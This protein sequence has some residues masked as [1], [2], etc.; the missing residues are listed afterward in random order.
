MKKRIRG[1]TSASRGEKGRKR[2]EMDAV[3]REWQNGASERRASS[4]RKVAKNEEGGGPFRAC[5]NSFVRK[6]RGD[7]IYDDGKRETVDRSVGR[8][9]DERERE[10][11]SRA[12]G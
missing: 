12:S 1:M 2:E 11:E 8:M 6:T 10:R 9:N 4:W 7:G 5:G 3:E